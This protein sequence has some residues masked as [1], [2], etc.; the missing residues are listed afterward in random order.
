MNFLKLL[1]AHKKLE[2]YHASTASFKKFLS[3]PTWFSLNK[4]NAH[5][6]HHGNGQGDESITYVCEF[7]GNVASEKEAEDIAK[8]IWPN[9]DFI[10][11]MYDVNVG[12]F[13]KEEV[14][15]FIKALIEKGF[16]AAYIQDYDPAN[17]GEGSSRS[18]AVFRPDIHVKIKGTIDI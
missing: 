18:L 14:E 3:R 5:G 17:Y 1:E 12:E 10:Y 11:S 13:E 4:K 6:W 9:D 8:T 16:D 15:A 7:N 2:V